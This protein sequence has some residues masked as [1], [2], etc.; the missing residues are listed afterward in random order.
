MKRLRSGAQRYAKERCGRG[1]VDRNGVVACWLGEEDG[2][3][4]GLDG[5]PVAGEFADANSFLG[6]GVLTRRSQCRAPGALWRLGLCIGRGG[7]EPPL[8]GPEPAVLPLN[9]LPDE[10]AWYARVRAL[11]KTRLGWADERGYNGAM[12][13]GVRQPV[14]AGSFYPGDRARL[15]ALVEELLGEAAPERAPSSAGLIVPHAGYA[16]SGRIAGAGLCVAATFGRP[17][18]VIILGASHSGLGDALVV[19]G[20]A[21]WRTPLGDVPL[22]DGTIERLVSLGVSRSPDAFRREHSMEVVLPFLQIL[23]PEPTPV[24]P[25][26]V[27]LAPW[28]ALDE[29]A[30]R[31]GEALG[32]ERVWV[33]ASSDFTHYEPDA[34]ARALD[35]SALDLILAGDAQGFYRHTIERGLSICGAGAITVLL[36]L[37]RT[38]GLG[39][40]SLV[41]YATS[42]DITGDRSA[43]VGYAAVLFAKENS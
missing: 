33:V 11:V 5:P 15:R 10:T 42:G 39:R 26:C 18:A 22:D 20:D 16:Y 38:L 7:F 34:A 31:L 8:T 24:V 2:D 32:S 23:F 1:S 14:V 9:D 12:G 35:R 43:V 29:G 3:W 13:S 17:E 36:L 28:A 4:R 25:V 37:A 21:A 27:Q 30:R 19:P 41:D 40:S 6:V